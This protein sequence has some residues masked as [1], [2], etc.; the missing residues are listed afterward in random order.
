MI[1]KK[2]E[3]RMSKDFIGAY[4]YYK[5]YKLFGF[6]TIYKKEISFMEYY[7]KGSEDY[8]ND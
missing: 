7:Y 5:I 3:R 1:S 8:E 2:Y 4:D 6:I